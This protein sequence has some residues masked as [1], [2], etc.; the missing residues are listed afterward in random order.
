MLKPTKINCVLLVD[1]NASTNFLNKKT[2]SATG[3]V[4]KINVATN[5]IEALDYIQKSGKSNDEEYPKPNIIF[6]DVNMPKMGGFEFLEHYEKLDEKLKADVVV[7]FLTTSNWK[8]DKLEAFSSK[9]VND[10]IEKPLE[11]EKFIE[12]CNNYIKS[13]E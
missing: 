12:I 13:K 8:K 9:I 2:I 6:L 7:V 4:N 1:D 11:K 3:F 5:G 10:F